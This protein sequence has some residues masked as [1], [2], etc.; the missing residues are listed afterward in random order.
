MLTLLYAE[1]ALLAEF[2]CRDTINSRL[3]NKARPLG[4]RKTEESIMTI[5][6]SH[7]NSWSLRALLTATALGLG[8][9]AAF[10]ADPIKIGVIAEAQAIAGASIPQAAQLAADEINAKAASTAA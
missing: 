8:A 4:G 3:I 2:H 10:A 9:S 5:R 7:R 6:I 1:A